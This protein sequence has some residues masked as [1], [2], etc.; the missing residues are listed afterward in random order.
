MIIKKLLTPENLLISIAILLLVLFPFLI[1][2]NLIIESSLLIFIV[3]YSSAILIFISLIFRI[4]S[5]E[6]ALAE[7]LRKERDSNY[8]FQNEIFRQLDYLKQDLPNR[9]SFD[10]FRQTSYENFKNQSTQITNINNSI[11]RI[12]NVISENRNKWDERP[13]VQT[14]YI[15]YS[16]LNPADLGQILITYN[17]LYNLIFNSSDKD[18]N[19]SIEPAREFLEIISVHTGNSIIFKTKAKGWIPNFDTKKGDILVTIPK[20]YLVLFFIGL[21]LERMFSFGISNYKEL[22]EIKNYDLQNEKLEKELKKLENEVDDSNQ[23]SK[24]KIQT[25]LNIIYNITVINQN[26]NKVEVNQNLPRY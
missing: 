13:G 9:Y 20:Q 2:T 10:N 4:K 21:I 12:Q 25:E 14:I 22:L 23:D 19:N 5:K 8:K 18:L 1:Y 3:C 16:I 7:N 11:H 26:I 15:D 6:N 24:D 17:N